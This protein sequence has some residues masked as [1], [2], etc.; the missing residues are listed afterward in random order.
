MKIQGP[1]HSDG[2]SGSFAGIMTA[3]TWKGR[4]YMR[5]LV[6]PS[7]PKSAMQVSTRSMFRFLST[8]WAD[9][10]D[11]AQASWET[12]AASRNYSPFN[13]YQ[14]FNMERWSRALAPMVDPEIA[15]G[16]LGTE[17]TWTATAGVRSVT[18]TLG[19]NGPDENWGAVIYQE[20][21]SAPEGT[22]DEVVWVEQIIDAIGHTILFTGLTPGLVY[23]YKYKLFTTGGLY[24]LLSADVNATPTT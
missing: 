11:A 20:I 19:L 2:A 17:D 10:G 14:S 15:P 22:Q 4:P 8:G 16:D 9:I 5:Q 24:G 1:M 23:H 3:A 12:R 13:A 7:N 18:L 6:K 21:G